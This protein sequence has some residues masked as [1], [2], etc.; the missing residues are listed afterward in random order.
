MTSTGAAPMEPEACIQR[1]LEVA[2]AIFAL[3]EGVPAWEEQ[4]ES[5]MKQMFSNPESLAKIPSLNCTPLDQLPVGSLVRYRCMVQDVRDPEYYMG[6][7]NQA[8]VHTGHSCLATAKYR[9]AIPA[10]GSP[11]EAAAPMERLPLH[12]TAIPGQ[13]LWA[14][15]A[16]A[17]ECAPAA[18]VCAHSSG[19]QKRRADDSDDIAA[20]IT[21]TTEDSK[22]RAAAVAPALPQAVLGSHMCMLCPPASLLPGPV[23]A[24]RGQQ[25]NASAAS[26]AGTQ[27]CLV[28]V[29]DAAGQ[30]IRVNQAMEF[31][32]ILSIEPGLATFDS[33]RAGD[34]L[35][36]REEH[37]A[38]YS[39]LPRLHAVFHRV[40]DL[41]MEPRFPPTMQAEVAAVAL[42]PT[43]VGTG[44]S[45]RDGFVSAATAA[46][47][48]DRLAAEYASTAQLHYMTFPYC[49]GSL[50]H[51]C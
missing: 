7:Y 46:L 17:A 47:G 24:L 2:Q 12:C 49:L 11:I 45:L 18:V 21:A 30:Q 44:L 39:V 42:L 43:L 31:V 48:G 13:T 27:A 23:D 51:G 15:D 50:G 34:D 9:D 16:I 19:T 3:A 25:R 4:F 8:D 32:G 38:P 22:R 37:H 20:P 10:Y 6:T 35:N 14:M 5:V 29:Y 28:K 41:V 33:A 26:G 40:V 1:P 36:W